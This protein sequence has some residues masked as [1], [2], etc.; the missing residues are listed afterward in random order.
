MQEESDDKS[1]AVGLDNVS[2]RVGNRQILETISL[3]IPEGRIT[4]ILGL[5]GAGK[6]TL[7][8][9]ILGLKSPTSGNVT[10]LGHRAGSRTVKQRVGAVLQ[11]VAL[12]EELSPKE[13]L[14]FAASLYG[15]ANAGI[16]IAQVLDLIGLA[17]RR[18]DAASIL[19]GGMRRR[20]TIG[21]ALLHEPD[22][23]VIDEPT[24]GVDAEARHDIWSHLRLLRSQGTTVIVSTNYLDEALALC[25]TAAVLR[26]GR[27]L[28]V[29]APQDL[30]ARAGSCLEIEYDEWDKARIQAALASRSDVL[31][32]EASSTG[33]TI[34][35]E[36][37]ASADTVLRQLLDTATLK[38]FR[39]R[40]P[41]LAEVF[42]A[43][44]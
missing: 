35:L 13:N 17:D 8:S 40:A 31:R 14:N 18:D 10:V 4:G 19:S 41:D 37:R 1:V 33:T 6:S 27:L 38:A 5:N 15:I 34:F 9:L 28:L 29:E 25:D 11:E 20:L 3:A 16:R 24:L 22:I 21:R 26:G 36:G 30:V 39:V 12:Y 23:L 43:I 32:T 2:Y 44:G 7:L 42:K